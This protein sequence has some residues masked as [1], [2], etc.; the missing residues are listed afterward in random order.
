MHDQLATSSCGIQ[1]LVQAPNTTTACRERL[2]GFYEMGERASE[3]VQLPDHQASS[4]TASLQR[5]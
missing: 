1:V 3:A 4:S 5:R 2:D